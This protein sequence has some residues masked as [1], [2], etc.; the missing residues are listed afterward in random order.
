MNSKRR[1][2]GNSDDFKICMI[3]HLSKYKKI[4]NW[5]IALPID[6]LYEIRTI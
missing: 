2:S 1:I 4:K 3:A 5:N 6:S